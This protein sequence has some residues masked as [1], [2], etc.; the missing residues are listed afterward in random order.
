MPGMN[1]YD[2]SKQISAVCGRAVKCLFV[3]GYTADV[4]RTH[5]V[6]ERTQNLLMKPFSKQELVDKVRELLA[7]AQEELP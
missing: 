5:G 7:E 6:D 2:L 4:I 1:G 3:S